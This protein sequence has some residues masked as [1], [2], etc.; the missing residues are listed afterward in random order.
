MTSVFFIIAFFGSL[1]AVFFWFMVVS[2][3]ATEQRHKLFLWCMSH[4]NYVELLAMFNAVT[5]KQHYR[6][7]FM[8]HLKTWRNIYDPELFST[9]H[10]IKHGPNKNFNR[11]GTTGPR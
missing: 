7:I 4:N 3:I 6:E 5:F 10:L 1:L 11:T 8:L 2:I 9:F